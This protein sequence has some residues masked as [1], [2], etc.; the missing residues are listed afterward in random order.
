[1]AMAGSVNDLSQDVR[2]AVAMTGGVSLAVWMGGVAR[3]INLLQQ[4]SNL[5]P[6]DA[7]APGAA[8]GPDGGKAAPA[9]ATWD[10]RSRDLYLGLLNVLD[11]T[12]T[13]DVLSGTS[14]G[15]INAAMLGLSSAAGVDLAE[16]RD[17][18]LTAGSLD[19]LLRDPGEKN[20][21]ALMQGDKVLYLQ[22]ARGI[23]KFYR[24]RDSAPRPPQ[25]VDTTVYI[26]TTLLGGETSRFTDDYGTLVADVDHH[27]LF[28]F[29][30]EALSPA[31]AD[32]DS[33]TA[34]ALAARSSASFPAAFEPSFVPFDEHV[35]A[36]SGVPSRPDMSPFANTTRSHW[37]ADGGILANRPLAP[38]LGAVFARPASPEGREVRRVL[39][40]V[41]PDGGGTANPQDVPDKDKWANAPTMIGALKADMN[42]Q[43]SQSIASDLEAIRKHNDQIRSDHD[44]RRTL[45]EF[46]VRLP[47]HRLVT[48]RMLRDFERQQGRGLAEP[49]MDELMRRL[50]TMNLPSRWAAEFA[51]G[52][53]STEN[54]MADEMVAV[55]GCGWRDG[56]AQDDGAPGVESDAW[57]QIAESEIPILAARFGLPAF[58]A[59][60]SAAVRLVKLAN[61]QAVDADQRRAIAAIRARLEAAFDPPETWNAERDRIRTLVDSS[62]Q[63]A[64]GSPETT[65][66]QLAH[67]LAD[68]RRS[69]L[70]I[71][72]MPSATLAAGWQNVA[73]VVA[74]LGT[75]LR[76]TSG[77]TARPSRLDVR[78]TLQAYL[79]YFGGPGDPNQVCDQLLSL[80]IAERA[81]QPA[82]PDVDQPVEFIQVSANTRTLLAPIEES[83]PASQQLDCVD[84]LRG[85]ELHHFAAFYKSS[86]RAYDWMWG[87]LDGSG[88]L[89][90][91]LLDPRRILAVVENSPDTAAHG[92]RARQFADRLRTELGLPAGLPDDCL[93]VDLAFLDDPTAQPPD[94]LPNSALFLAQAWQ[95]VIAANELPVIAER[96]LADAGRLQPLTDPQIHA[97]VKPG[98]VSA[99]T[100]RAREI[101]YRAAGNRR[102]G[103]RQSEPPNL[104]ATKVLNLGRDKTV[105][106]EML[107]R[108]LPECPVRWETLGGELHSPAFART[109]TKAAAVTT[110]ALSATP[111]TPATFRSTLAGARSITR[112]GYLATKATGGSG[113]KTLLLGVV[114]AVIGIVLATQSVIVVGVTG[115]ITALVGLY[116][117]ALGSWGIHRGLLGALI[118]ITAFAAVGSLALAWVR[119]EIWGS[120]GTNGVVPEHVLPW[121]RNSWWGGLALLG[122]LFGIAVL[123]NLVTRRR[124]TSQPGSKRL[125]RTG[126][127][128]GPDQPDTR[129]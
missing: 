41:V 71:G 116:L 47:D 58:H 16:L 74:D 62:V 22:L 90:H 40:Y 129:G 7:V 102:H 26:T 96:I 14:A 3:E 44:L 23:E 5:R 73:S 77:A 117:I 52:K 10:L 36:E 76:N 51:P 34:L 121:L 8:P 24:E 84:K 119:R 67:D 59:A 20:P 68:A 85:V 46:G 111:E 28:T 45:A 100:A 60:R 107:A 114:L 6:R 29:T 2:V 55:L 122:G 88:W 79:D 81:L 53:R 50:S 123:I 91:I 17:L 106:A 32:A 104:W 120:N 19:V 66:L 78:D 54:R 70:L 65:L 94:S 64:Q 25:G 92:G 125:V 38:L 87:R 35:P 56:L 63:S 118:A 97:S 31:S 57:D 93:E 30:Q 98:R 126:P 113:W 1:M 27:G 112:T 4:A 12:V 89:V 69:E 18:W 61:Q 115:T 33:L 11:V 43:L 99:L 101:W 127:T 9:N 109:A 86:W 15:G 37:A 95:R 21:S 83:V 80:V 124:P 108:E 42:A 128:A 103:R 75:T 49:L 110:A 82:E 105:P 48:P 72:V 13:V 39:T